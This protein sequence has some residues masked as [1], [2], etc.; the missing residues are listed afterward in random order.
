MR[1]SED[2]GLKREILIETELK[3]ERANRTLRMSGTSEKRST[4]P[5]S[6]SK[7]FLIVGASQNRPGEKKKKVGGLEKWEGSNAHNSKGLWGK[8]GAERNH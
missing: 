1:V 7:G 8:K 4:S 3:E 6:K 2:G 5:E